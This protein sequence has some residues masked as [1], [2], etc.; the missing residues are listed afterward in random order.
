MK[1]VF[2]LAMAIISTSVMADQCELVSSTMAKRATL[3]LQ[4]GAEIASV[5]EPCGE[6]VSSAKVTVVRSVK[7]V[8]GIY[9]NLQ[10]LLVN[11]KETDLA[12]TYLKVAPNRY[13]NVANAIG[14][15]A[16]GVSPMISK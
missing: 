15:K 10:G 6:K 12:Y 9:A 13:V 7:T 4:N 11:G 2:L 1:K 5:C 16:E 3:L 14:C 8:S